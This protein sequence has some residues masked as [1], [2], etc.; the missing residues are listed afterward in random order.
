MVWQKNTA[1]GGRSWTSRP[2]ITLPDRNECFCDAKTKPLYC[3]EIAMQWFYKKTW[4]VIFQW[5]KWIRFQQSQIFQAK[6]FRD[7]ESFVAIVDGEFFE[8][9]KP[10]ISG[11]FPSEIS[12]WRRSLSFP[13]VYYIYVGFIHLELWI[14]D[15]HT[16]LMKSLSTFIRSHSANKEATTDDKQL[17]EAGVL[18]LCDTVAKPGVIQI[19]T[20]VAKK[21]P[22]W[23]I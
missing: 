9:R 5:R 1:L 8:I 21:K 7:R 6:T 15:R 11:P 14:E 4:E 2:V 18:Y 3:R 13:C 20:V 19:D 22:L 23:V 12:F 16:M 10:E 17:T